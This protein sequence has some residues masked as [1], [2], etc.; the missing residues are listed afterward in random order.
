MISRDASVSSILLVVLGCII[1]YCG[2]SIFPSPE[3]R[4]YGSN[5]GWRLR[6][7]PNSKRNIRSTETETVIVPYFGL[8][9]KFESFGQG[10]NFAVNYSPQVTWSSWI[11][12]CKVLE[13]VNKASVPVHLEISAKIQDHDSNQNE[14]NFGS[15]R[16]LDEDAPDYFGSAKS[17]RTYKYLLA[18]YIRDVLV[19]SNACYISVE[20]GFNVEYNSAFHLTWKL[21]ECLLAINAFI[22][23][24]S[25]VMVARSIRK[26][27]YSNDIQ[28]I[29]LLQCSKMSKN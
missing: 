5:N 26:D 10:C 18:G 12:L 3:I 9:T 25:V 23:G 27:I 6:I 28:S 19:K 22:N 20:T 14:V 21:S 1:N 8:I 4:R 11:T 29:S 2:T 24:S 16:F 7:S 13:I 15:L 17:N